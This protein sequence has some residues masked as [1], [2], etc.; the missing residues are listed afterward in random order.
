VNLAGRPP[1]LRVLAP[2]RL[3]AAVGA[4]YHR[5]LRVRVVDGD[6]APLQGASVTFTLGSAGGGGGGGAGSTAAAG[7]SFVGGQAQATET[8]DAAGV[9]TSP[10]FSANA[11]PG[12]FTATATTTGTTDAASFALDNLAARPPAIAVLGGT[13]RSAGVNAN[14]ASPLQVRVL[15]SGKPLQGASVTFTLGSGGSGGGGAGGGGTG[16][17]AAGASFVGGGSQATETTDAAGIATSPRF[18]ANGTPGRFTATATTAGT[19]DAGL[20]A[21]DNMAGRP[22]TIAVVGASQRT[23][24]VGAHYAEPLQVRVL[25]AGKPVQG[26]TVT[27]SLGSGGG[28]G[29]GGAGGGAGASPG[30]TF[31]GGTSQATATT[32]AAGLAVSPRLGANDTAGT[33]AATA[34]T[35]GT[36]DA[37]GF[38]LRNLAGAPTMLAA[39]AAS[40]QST[41]VGTRFPVPL[42]VTVTDKSGN[43]VAGVAVTFAA[44]AGGAT[45]RFAGGRR[46]VTVK[47]GTTGVAVAPPFAANR[48][49]GG[50]VVRA[51][52]GGHATAFALV[53]LPAA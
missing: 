48:A 19:T 52:A 9:A 29:G 21:L 42:A 26:A 41:V 20:F 38:T 7:A 14:Y 1:T 28:G 4:R 53:N 32:D 6:G 30:A 24:T 22:P 46:T 47:T 40:T 45:G 44:P 49:S 15:Q 13:H 23:A 11:T 36:A 25:Q 10:A 35:T 51:G 43:P 18:A 8:T 2:A 5:S 12:R 16:S 3:S 27:F 39:G 17:G 37:A 34:T 50:Y 31:A 33:F